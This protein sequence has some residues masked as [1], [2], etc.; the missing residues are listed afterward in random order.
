MRADLQPRAPAA[1]EEIQA[2]IE[3]ANAAAQA[4]ASDAAR[5]AATAASEAVAQGA[6][7]RGSVSALRDGAGRIVVRTADGRT[8]IVD[9]RAVP[10]DQ[11]REAI[12]L[13]SLAGPPPPPP[14]QHDIPHEVIPL[15]GI[16]FG[17]LTTM[18]LGLPIIRAMIRRSERRATGV[19][20]ALPAELGGRLER[21]EQ[22]VEA[23]AIEVER[24][25]EA[26]RFQT[27]VLS[28]RGDARAPLLAEEVG[29]VR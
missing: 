8:I 11:A 10:S 18:V 1:R 14:P 5:D 7:A 21:I 23:V 3:A 29:H 6:A 15:V 24:I 25:S 2:A 27:R 17:C 28:E 19:P 26:Q 22:A 13:Q 4:A 9:P 20:P 12:I 16:V